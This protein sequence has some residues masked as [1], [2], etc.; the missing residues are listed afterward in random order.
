[1]K[2]CLLLA[3]CLF[4][5]SACGASDITRE[6]YVFGTRVEI[7]V[8]GEDAANAEPVINAAL[9]DLDHL[10]A[11][12]HAWK[13]SPVTRINA[14]FAAGKT[15]PLTPTIAEMIQHGTWAWQQSEGLFNPTIG[16]L[17]ATWGFHQDTFAPVVPNQTLIQTWL[18]AQPSP[19]DFQIAGDQISSRNPAAQLD[20]GGI[21]KGWVLDRIAARL[22]QAHINNALINI[23]G[24]ILALGQH[25]HKPWRIGL[26]HPR[27]PQAMLE[28]ELRDGEAIGTS[29][30]YQRFFMLQG[31][32]YSH[33]L[34]P[35]QGQPATSAMTA[36]ALV[37][38][39]PQAGLISDAATKPL[40]IGGPDRAAYYAQRFKI[41][42][43]LVV[44]PVGTVYLSQS[45]QP[46]VHWLITPPQI[47]VI[48]P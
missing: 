19:T 9:A 7:T 3:C 31:K 40:F 43:W 35:R 27:Q 6:S 42:N 16:G 30:D 10:H 1:M 41:R 45:M 26:Q 14:A 34:D 25:Q 5:L 2:H 20:F 15:A 38:A 4:L 24:N 13:N 47:R 39:G 48:G 8:S 32:R 23:G 46:R 12:L 18:K 33:L 28:L 44:S 37:D 22:K 21:A 17:V 29:G 36:T 11:E